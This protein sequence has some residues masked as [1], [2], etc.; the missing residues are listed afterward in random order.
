MLPASPLEAY[1]W[2]QMSLKIE[3]GHLSASLEIEGRKLQTKKDLKIF[4]N[5]DSLKSADRIEFGRDLIGKLKVP[6]LS[7]FSL[8]AK[9]ASC[10]FEK[11]LRRK[12]KMQN[13]YF[14]VFDQI[15][16][17]RRK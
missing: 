3:D 16:Q 14:I 1:K 11:I 13:S 17:K 15:M 6:A 12:A 5:V 9:T 7:F 4:E 10:I 8:I 2:Y